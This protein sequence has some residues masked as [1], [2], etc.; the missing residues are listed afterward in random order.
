MINID[1]LNNGQIIAYGTTITDSVRTEK[2]HFNF[3]ESWNGYVKKAL[4]KNGEKTVGVFLNADQTICTGEDECFVPHEVIKAPQFTVSVFGVSGDS[5]VTSEQ[6]IIKVTESG[7][8]KGDFPA[9]PS[10]T[11]YE[12]LL[13][14]AA[15]TKQIAQSVR[16][17]ADNGNFKGEKGD[18]GPQGEKGEKGEKG[19]T[20]EQGVQG[21]QGEKGDKGDKGAAFTY[22][23]F[24]PEQLA[25]LKG[26]KG[27]NGTDGKDG[28][29]PQ[30]G[31]DYFTDEDIAGLN[32]PKVDQYYNATSENALSG[33]AISEVVESKAD[34]GYI[35]NNFA[36]ALKG[37]KSG[38]SIL[39]DD[40]S[41]VKHPVKIKINS[42]DVRDLT[43]VKV[44]MFGKNLITFPYFYNRL[45][46]IGYT[47]TNG[48]ITFTVNEDRSITANG[49]ATTDAVFSFYDATLNKALVS[50]VNKQ[51]VT[52]SGCPSGGSSTTYFLTQRNYGFKDIG[53]GIK[54]QTCTGMNTYAIMIKSG[55]TVENLIFKPQLELG[56]KATEYEPFLMPIECTPNADGNVDNIE[57]IY[58][59]MSLMTDTDGVL[60]DCEYNRD[61]HK[62]I[63]NIQSAITALGG[64]I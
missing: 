59:N 14:I 61:I 62:V 27:D 33:K 60:I 53:S 13:N 48:G 47:E 46:G 18:T 56:I 51:F 39:I 6:A 58:P 55:T 30:K 17:D 20:G 40:I 10:P 21:I 24:T 36:N 7:Y 25:E 28:Y 1:I 3:P 16:T 4:F 11:E 19:D 54:F 15:E 35:N 41:N 64:E 32:I 52:L 26:E 50:N 34:T 29:T 8:T 12:Q 42:D 23:N 45:K 22:A 2:I 43:S 49:T 5:R 63:A 57:S 37:S 31:V 38:S 44:K 9:N